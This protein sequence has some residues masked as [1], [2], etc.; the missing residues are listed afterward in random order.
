M[1]RRGRELWHFIKKHVMQI[2]IVQEVE[3]ASESGRGCGSHA[4]G[5]G[6]LVGCRGGEAA[7]GV[8]PSRQSVSRSSIGDSVTARDQ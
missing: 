4:T 5:R 2:V 3:A 8:R 6:E 1:R 7:A